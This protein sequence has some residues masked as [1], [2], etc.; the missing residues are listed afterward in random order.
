M[1]SHACHAHKVP[2]C[3]TPAAARYLQ[4]SELEAV[5]SAMHRMRTAVSSP[6]TRLLWKLPDQAP[7]AFAAVRGGCW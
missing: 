7:D 4:R 6:T 2:P 5:V 1:C 3:A